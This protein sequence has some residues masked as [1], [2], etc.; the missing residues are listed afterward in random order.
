VQSDNRSPEWE[1]GNPYRSPEKTHEGPLPQSEHRR[2][3]RK[4]LIPATLL[5][6]FCPVIL[7]GYLCSIGTVV[8]V[9]VHRRWI[10]PDLEGLQ[11]FNRRILSPP[12]VAHCIFGIA[13][14]LCGIFAASAWMRGNWRWAV[15]LTVSFCLLLAVV[16]YISSGI[17]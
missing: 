3:F 11:Y 7:L 13:G 17:Q 10:E 2:R 15:V 4:R 1:N 14:A 5:W 9:N 12:I 16:G 6:S 8:Y